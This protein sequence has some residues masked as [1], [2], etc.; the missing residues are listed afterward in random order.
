MQ[1]P[2][3][4]RALTIDVENY[5]SSETL[6]FGCETP[7]ASSVTMIS[8]HV[9]PIASSV[10]MISGHSDPVNNHIQTFDAGSNCPSSHAPIK[11]MAKDQDKTPDEQDA[12]VYFCC[13]YLQTNQCHD[14]IQALY[15]KE[16]PTKKEGLGTN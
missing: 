1:S 4:S 9:T 11:P 6:N 14:W 15:C 10:T 2:T 13:H 8:G 12:C 3:N 5:P 16:N 7:V